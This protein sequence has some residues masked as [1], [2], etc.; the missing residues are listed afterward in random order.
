MTEN[1]LIKGTVVASIHLPVIVT[2]NHYLL[3]VR[4]IGSFTW[5][6]S[7]V[8]FDSIKAAEKHCLNLPEP[9]EFYRIIEVTIPVNKL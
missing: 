1:N 2:S 4:P 6:C 7:P 5:S 3:L 8:V 9:V